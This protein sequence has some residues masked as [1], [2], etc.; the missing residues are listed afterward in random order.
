MR[1]VLP[2][3]IAFYSNVYFPSNRTFF[4]KCSRNMLSYLYLEWTF[5]LTFLSLK[6]CLICHENVINLCQIQTFWCLRHFPSEQ[7]CGNMYVCRFW[8]VTSVLKITTRIPVGYVSLLHI[9]ILH[10]SMPAC[11]LHDIDN[12]KY[13][14]FHGEIIGLS[15]CHKSFAACWLPHWNVAC[16]MLNSNFFPN[17]NAMG[18]Y[19]SQNS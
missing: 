7:F 16:S 8:R 2:S 10:D 9:G 5:I 4:F 13:T 17:T 19:A 1:G 14:N 12:L 18:K 15:Q 3:L 6:S 11:L